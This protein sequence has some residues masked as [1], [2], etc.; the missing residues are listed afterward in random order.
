MSN[1]KERVTLSCGCGCGN[2]IRPRTPRQLERDL[3]KSLS[4]NLFFN[5]N[6]FGRWSY[7]NQIE[8]RK[9]QELQ[10]YWNKIPYITYQSKRIKSMGNLLD[11]IDIPDS[12]PLGGHSAPT[13]SNFKVKGMA[14]E[15]EQ[16]NPLEE[17]K[18]ELLAQV[19]KIQSEIDGTPAN[20]MTLTEATA[21]KL[22]NVRIN[23]G[24]PTR[25]FIDDKFPENKTVSLC[26]NPPIQITQDLIGRI[27]IDTPENLLTDG[28]GNPVTEL[29][30]CRAE[31][32]FWTV[33]GN[34]P[35]KRNPYNTDEE[36]GEYVKL[37]PNPESEFS[38]PHCFYCSEPVPG[39]PT[40]KDGRPLRWQTAPGTMKERQIAWRWQSFD[41]PEARPGP[42]RQTFTGTM[43]EYLVHIK[44]THPISGSASTPTAPSIPVQQALE[45]ESVS[46]EADDNSDLPPSL[47]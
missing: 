28:A 12:T 44:A 25:K 11:L 43:D 27:W 42:G 37:I 45:T 4:G 23:N 24:N 9:E 17:K 32:G 41:G 36:N 8:L 47:R 34:D 14:D 38:D 39:S 15:I 3:A 7:R 29:P 19:A 13:N 22:G 6:H 31:L 20:P 30:A 40:D 21:Q 10:D 33:I 46:V 35:T 5:Q 16:V 2:D 26:Y 18:N 1:L